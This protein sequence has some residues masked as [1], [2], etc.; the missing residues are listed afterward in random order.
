MKNFDSKSTNFYII[1]QEADPSTGNAP[2][3]PPNGVRV[4]DNKLNLVFRGLNVNNNITDI[5]EPKSISNLTTGNIFDFILYPNPVVSRTTIEFNLNKESNVSIEIFDL[6]GNK[7]TTIHNGKLNPGTYHAL[8][9]P[10][11][12]ANGIYICKVIVEGQPVIKKMIIAR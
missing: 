11:G 2:T 1:T 7:I 12:L 6:F 3:N 9:E 10:N 4:G 5:E 8:F